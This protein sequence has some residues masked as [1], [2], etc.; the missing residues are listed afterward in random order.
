MRQALRLHGDFEVV[1]DVADGLSAIEAALAHTPDVVVLDLGLPDLAGAELVTRVRDV[2][3]RARIVVYTG[4]VVREGSSIA[5]TAD[6]VIQKDQSVRYLVGL[7]ANFD[8]DAPF[9]VAIKLGP[10]TED[11]R[12]ARRFLQDHCERWGCAKY[13]PDVN[14]VLSELVTNAL[15]H[16]GTSCEF[17]ARFSQGRLRLEVRDDG[18]GTPDLKAAPA[19]SED[20]RGLMIVSSLA[21]AWG[22]ETEADGGKTVWAELEVAGPPR[23]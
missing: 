23:S 6:V 11:V 17:R 14:L 22:V 12:V 16:A 5:T 15:T 3:P 9:T 13:L 19:E 8:R 18:H 4:T 20:G 1:A 10:S 7:L 21:E 2:A